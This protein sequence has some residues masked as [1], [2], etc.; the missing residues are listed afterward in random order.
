MRVAAIFGVA[1]AADTHKSR[2]RHALSR[3]ICSLRS[4]RM[5]A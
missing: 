4:L 2:R 1:V 5:T 3:K